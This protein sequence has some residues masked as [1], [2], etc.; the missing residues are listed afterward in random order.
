MLC[1]IN[2]YGLYLWD[3][4]T[5]AP[6]AVQH[7]LASQ[8]VCQY[9]AAPGPSSMEVGLLVPILIEINKIKAAY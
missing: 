9:L 7:S 4:R 1:S 6:L 3:H 5:I 8:Q 2:I